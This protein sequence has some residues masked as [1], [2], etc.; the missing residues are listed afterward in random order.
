MKDTKLWYARPAAG[1][2]QGLPIGNGRIGAVMHGG[3]GQE[4]WCM[5]EVTYWSGKPERTPGQEDPKGKLALMRERFFGGDYA[6]GDKLAK[7]WLEPKKGNFGTNL[8]LCDVRLRFGHE[9][10]ELVRELDLE[11]AVAAVSYKSGGQ[12]VTRETFAS[13]ADGIV[14]ARIAGGPAGGLSFSLRAEGRTPVFSAA[15]RNGDTIVFQGRAT[16]DVHSDGTCGV[17]CQGGIKVVIR[18]GSFDSS[19]D[20]IV[21]K[22]ADEAYLYFAVNTNYGRTDG[23]WAEESGRQIEA[24]VA[25]G[26]ERLREEHIADYRALYTRVSL[27]L[28]RTNQGGLPT[29]ER[30]KRFRAGETDDPGLIALFYQYGRYLTIAGSREDSPLP[31]HLQGLWNDGEANAMAWSC[32]YHLDINTQM[33]YY[34]TEIGNLAECHVPLMNYIGR[35]A[36]AGRMAAED[37]YGCEGWVAHVFSNAWGFAA[38]GWGTSWGLNVTGGLMIALHMK[39]HYEYGLDEAFLREQAYPVLKESALFFLDY[40]TVHPRH[41]WLV[42]GPSNSPENSFYPG[43]PADGAQQLSMGSTMDQI[44]V[45]DLFVF[46]LEA[47]GRL[48]LD[49]EL[50]ERLRR[51]IALLPPLR[52]GKRGQLQEWLEDYGEAQPE[53]RHLA[54]LVGLYPGSQITPKDT[55]ELSEAVRTTLYNRMTTDDL[56]DIEF[57]AALFA[58]GFSR[59]HDGNQA[60]KHIVHLIGDLCF[61][62]L[63]TYSKPGVAG[64]ETNIFV[65]DGN[66]GGAAAVADMLLQSHAGEL[67]LLPALPDAWRAGSF[68]GLRA[69]GGVEVDAAWEDGKL[70]GAT[71]KAHAAGRTTVRFGERT[72]PLDLAPGRVYAIDGQL[73]VRQA[74]AKQAE[75]AS[76]L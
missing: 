66:F 33:N 65:V 31:L 5:T 13:H 51:A 50:Q 55:P 60:V 40:M 58:V 11:T 32:D 35:L 69:K 29:D 18:G 9:G 23:D 17:S 63:L 56:E 52:I 10:E 42:T 19:E 21:V 67:H 49:E 4:T 72:V 12:A 3:I 59:L 48:Q 74:A 15:V 14:A 57:T 41:G 7:Q 37:F 39:E 26:Y 22:D 73:A 44:L 16:E 62:N 76:N 30:M 8:S 47:A 53:H 70:T 43:D 45:R 27:D 1:W 6:G 38:P 28:G 61:D 2:T 24:A 64:A 68:K 71:I 46:C 36:E 75:E 34:P 54:H 20:E 25:K